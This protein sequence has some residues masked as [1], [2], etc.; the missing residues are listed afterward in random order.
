MKKIYFWGFLFGLIFNAAIVFVPYFLGLESFVMTQYLMSEN[1]IGLVIT[2][3]PYLL[4]SFIVF[5]ASA[6]IF[7]WSIKN[8]L[9][10][11]F[12]SNALGFYILIAILAWIV[13]RVFSQI[14]IL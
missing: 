7:K 11:I 10:Q 12:L 14:E 13:S 2:S 5:V 9:V 8:S 3:L 6:W 1:I 4:V